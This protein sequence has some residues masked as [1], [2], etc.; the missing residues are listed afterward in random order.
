RQ[1]S[2]LLGR[3][4]TRQA[5]EQSGHRGP[6]TAQAWD[7]SRGH[8]MLAL[9]WYKTA[10]AKYP[11]CMKIT[12]VPFTS[13]CGRIKRGEQP[14]ATWQVDYVGPLRPSQGQKYI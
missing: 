7:L 9:R 3:R 13:T 4:A 11:V 1:C 12:K 8:P 6:I 2:I 14:F 10:C 5:H